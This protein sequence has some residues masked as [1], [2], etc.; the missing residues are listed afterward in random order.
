MAK[1]KIIWGTVAAVAAGAGYLIKN[2]DQRA[3]L[4]G[5]TK[6]QWAKISD[7]VG[8]KEEE[9]PLEQRI[10]HPDPLDINDNEMVAEGSTYSVDYYNKEHE[11]ED[12]STSSLDNTEVQRHH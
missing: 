8:E 5:S 1:G 12:T 7:M 2:P 6:K 10:G 11:N 9:V 3:K 4:V